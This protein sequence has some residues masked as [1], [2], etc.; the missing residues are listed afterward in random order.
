MYLS[1]V[2]NLIEPITMTLTGLHHKARSQ[3]AGLIESYR[4]VRPL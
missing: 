2:A 3:A 1:P 4:K